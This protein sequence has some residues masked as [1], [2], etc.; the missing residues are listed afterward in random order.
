MAF[1]A[2]STVAEA[3]ETA[4]VIHDGLSQLQG[5]PELK[6]AALAAV[7]LIDNN[8]ELKNAMMEL[9][10]TSDGTT[11][12]IIETTRDVSKDIEFEKPSND[13]DM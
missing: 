13:F 7:E 6:E 3:S 9:S 12:A 1:S 8:P 4:K 2:P 10:K 5:T 11:E